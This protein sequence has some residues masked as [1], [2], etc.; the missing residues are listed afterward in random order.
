M[1]LPIPEAQ[2]NPSPTTHLYIPLPIS[3]AQDNPS[4]TTH[5]FMRLPIPEVQDNPSPPIYACLS[6]SQRLRIILAHP[7]MHASP[8]PRG[9]AGQS[10]LP[11]LR[12]SR[13]SSPTHL[14]MPLP[15]VFSQQDNPSPTN[16][17]HM[18]LLISKAQDTPGPT[19]YSCLSAIQRLGT[20]M[21]H[22][23]I[24]DQKQQTESATVDVVI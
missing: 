23:S 21:A 18:L 17:L 14:F 6:P 1:R 16:H 2:D 7:S 11:H 13:Q 10:S 5:L 9:S 12:S 22:L 4:L 19:T 20:I 3:E 15:I 8:Q 24:I